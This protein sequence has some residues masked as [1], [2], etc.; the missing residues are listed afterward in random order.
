MIQFF[1]HEILLKIITYLLLLQVRV[2]KVKFIETVFPH[3]QQTPHSQVAICTGDEFVYESL[4]IRYIMIEMFSI[5]TFEILRV[6]A[7]ILLTPKA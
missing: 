7:T 5:L 3:I 2:W 6:Q 4:I 1:R